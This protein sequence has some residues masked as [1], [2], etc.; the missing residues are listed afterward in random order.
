LQA[1]CYCCVCFFYLFIFF[2]FF[3]F[4]FFRTKAFIS[5]FGL[6]SAQRRTASLVHDYFAVSRLRC[7][8][9]FCLLLVRLAFKTKQTI[10]HFFFF[11]GLI[12]SSTPS[13]CTNMF[14]ISTTNT[15][16]HG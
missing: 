5:L 11:S 14:T 8:W 12:G 3:P 16:H 6:D 1:N 4:L 2:F 9:R 10:P 13:F 15:V 7:L